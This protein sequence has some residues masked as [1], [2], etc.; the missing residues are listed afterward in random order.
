M[1][2]KTTSYSSNGE[3]SSLT[4]RIQKD[5][6][7]SNEVHSSLFLLKVRLQKKTLNEVVEVLLEHY[8]HVYQL[9]NKE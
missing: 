6:I 7:V 3:I 8:S 5:L 9:E 2:R 1:G 4:E